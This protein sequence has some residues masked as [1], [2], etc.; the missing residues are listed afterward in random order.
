MNKIPDEIYQAHTILE[1]YVVIHDTIFKFSWRKA[2]PIPGIFKPIDYGQHAEELNA[3]ASALQQ[4]IIT[5]ANKTDIPDVFQK[6]VAA[7]FETIKFL[8][9]ICTR[10]YHKSEGDL[11]S[12]PMNE[13]K[14][15]M[16]RY[17]DLVN[18]Y[19][20][21]GSAVNEYIYK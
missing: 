14:A 19:H 6:F 9:D 10:L 20:S 7:L 12:Y 5:I 3:L 1:R 11:Q 17:E 4:I 13:Y 18:R 21:L 16:A 2:I 8:R 15:D